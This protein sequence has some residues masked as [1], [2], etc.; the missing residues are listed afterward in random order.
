VLLFH[1]GYFLVPSVEANLL[2]G[3]FIGVDL[4]FVLSGFLMTNILLEPK[5]SYRAFYARRVARI[6]PAL[7]VF[8]LADLVFIWAT[9]P[10]VVSRLRSDALIALGLGNWGDHLRVVLP[11]DLGQTWSLGVEEQ[12]YLLW[13]LALITLGRRDPRTVSR[14]CLVGIGA[15]FVIKFAMFKSGVPTYHIYGQTEV[16]LDDFLAGA[17]VA[18]LWVRRTAPIRHLRPLALLAAAVFITALAVAH[19]YTSKWLYEG[20]FT[21]IAIAGAFLLYA[22]LHEVQGTGF[23]AGRLLRT[24]GRYSYAIYLWHPL[25]IVAANRFIPHSVPLR[26]LAT[27][28]VL[29]GVSV[30]ST[31]MIEEPLRRLV[32]ARTG[33]TSGRARVPALLGPALSEAVASG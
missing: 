22:S 20:G 28:V 6:F 10:G 17:F 30:L 23:L 33:R 19:P 5:H 2:P 4:F 25:V 29:G 9:G 1:A 32:A 26:V 18:T 15:A 11:F 31:K 14:I 3:G 27:V 12:L 13:P 24:A 16:R 8:L 21:A 7:Y